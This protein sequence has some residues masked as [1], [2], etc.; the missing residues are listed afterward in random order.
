MPYDE[1]YLTTIYLPYSSQISANTKWI[2][3][4]YKNTI[5]AKKED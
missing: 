3:K 4:A 5:K 1:K 2:L